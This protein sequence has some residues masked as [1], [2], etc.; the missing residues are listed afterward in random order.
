M[1]A[2]WRAVG[3]GRRTSTV[4][5]SGRGGVVPTPQRIIKHPY[6]HL[7]YHQLLLPHVSVPDIGAVRHGKMHILAC[8]KVG[9]YSLSRCRGGGGGGGVL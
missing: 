5:D 2:V 8:L 7:G 4:P 6:Q 1:R 3:D 9:S